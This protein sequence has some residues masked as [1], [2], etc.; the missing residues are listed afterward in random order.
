ML[1]PG[2]CGLA[3]N[4]ES[5]LGVL[6]GR[7]HTVVARPEPTMEYPKQ[8]QMAFAAHRSRNVG[9]NMLTPMARSGES[10]R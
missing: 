5:G 3:S 9:I 1:A 4:F 7:C 6:S 8:D 10:R 2:A